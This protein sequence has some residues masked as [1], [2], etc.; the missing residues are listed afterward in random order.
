V[1]FNVARMLSFGDRLDR[2]NLQEYAVSTSHAYMSTLESSHHQPSTRMILATISGVIAVLVVM[3]LVAG[4]K[5]GWEKMIRLDCGGNLRELSV[6]LR[7]YAAAHNGHFPSTWG[8]L[9]FVRDEA[10]WAKLLCCPD[11]GHQVGT[12]A[13]VDLWSDYRLLPERSTNDSPYRIL[14][15]EP[16]SNHRAAGANV[17]FVDGSIQWWPE[18]RLMGSA[19]GITTSTATK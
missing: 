19:V 14:A 5:T 11:V 3:W 10:N 15:V 7:E 17:L 16:L 18:S 9:N 6:P 8:E 2:L 1:F 12:W 4:F 13:Q